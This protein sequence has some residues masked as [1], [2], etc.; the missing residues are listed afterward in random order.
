[1][2]QHFWKSRAIK[3]SAAADEAGFTLI[4]VVVSAVIL[5]IIGLTLIQ[6]LRLAQEIGLRGY[7]RM[8]LQQEA[9][10]LFAMAGDGGFREGNGQ[11]G[12]E[13]D[14]AYDR[15]PG[16]HGL[17]ANP[18]GSSLSREDIT[19]YRL[20]LRNSDSGGFLQSQEAEKV[21]LRCQRAGYPLADCQ[22]LEERHVDGLV[23]AHPT[24]TG[25]SQ[26][27]IAGKTPELR[28]ILVDPAQLTGLDSSKSVAVE[29][30]TQSF[31]TAYR[32]EVD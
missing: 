22:N 27:N 12:I 2:G 29:K 25:N 32:L 19:P 21:T 14:H 13:R 24:T 17:S 8:K 30:F 15:V 31:W 11:S 9:Q 28:F 23:A 18:L 20:T 10:Y 6:I 26:R 5:S 1:M 4:E 16:F 7:T 3:R